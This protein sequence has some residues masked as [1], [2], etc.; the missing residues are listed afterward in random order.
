M[1]SR[2]SFR[3]DGRLYWQCAGCQTQCSVTSGTVFEAPKLPLTRWFLAMQL[4]TQAKNNV[5]ALELTRQLGVSYRT[6]WFIKLKLL[7]AMALAKS[8]RQLT[9]R[10]EVDD[11]YLGG[12]RSGGKAGRG[13]E[14]KVPF[15]V[16]VRTTEDGRAHRACLSARPFTKEAM[17]EFIA[18]NMGS[19]LTVVSDGLGCF[20]G[21]FSRTRRGTGAAAIRGTI[22][23][24]TPLVALP[25]ASLELSMWLTAG[26]S[27][28]SSSTAPS[29]ASAGS[30]RPM[31]SISPTASFRRS[32][33]LRVPRHPNALRRKLALKAH[34][35][36]AATVVLICRYEN[37]LPVACRRCAPALVGNGP[38]ALGQKV[39]GLHARSQRSLEPVRALADAAP[40]V[41]LIVFELHRFRAWLGNGTLGP[42]PRRL[43]AHRCGGLANLPGGFTETQLSCRQAVVGDSVLHLGDD[44]RHLLLSQGIGLRFK[45]SN[46]R[47]QCRQGRTTLASCH[48]ST[49]RVWSKAW[50]DMSIAS[51]CWLKQD[52]SAWLLLPAAGNL[53]LFAWLLTLHPRPRG[54]STR[55]TAATMWPWPSA[56]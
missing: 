21:H 42:L 18:T 12:E 49:L 54:G 32:M 40:C 29:Q 16:A 55:P 53:A 28:S 1:Q 52:R 19:P 47:V 46:L 43:A 11:A 7:Q 31:R 41:T 44:I 25:G 10:V 38:S 51:A 23:S 48:L 45:R 22:L 39:L 26:K 4:L 34:A 56:G 13:S 8:D 2:T 24:T 33:A 5:S 36:E 27:F 37:M 15:V 50:E 14:N 3:R 35:W 17:K 6:A 9:G 20:T 30:V